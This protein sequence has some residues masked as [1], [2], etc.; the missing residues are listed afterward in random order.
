VPQTP[1]RLLATVA[2]LTFTTVSAAVLIPNAARAQERPPLPDLTG[3]VKDEGWAQ[4]LGK[5][6]F[7]DTVARAS[8]SDCA[9]CH[10]VTGANR[11]IPDQSAPPLQ[12]L[13]AA[14]D[15]PVAEWLGSVPPDDR[16][17]IIDV[18]SRRISAQPPEM[19]DFGPL[20][21]ASRVADEDPSCKEDQTLRL[22]QALLEQKPLEARSINPDDGTF[23]PS[24]PHGNLVSPTGRGLERTYQWMIEQAFEE[25]LWKAADAATS[26]TP[27]D[28]AYSKVEKNFPLFWGIAVGV[29]ESTLDPRWT[30]DHEVAR[31][32]AVPASS[33]GQAEWE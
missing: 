32:L 27:A 5:A 18:C 17:G 20:R 11:R 26:Q 30:R 14:T 10:F 9:S 2:A 24:G 28:P 21:A 15:G 6:L 7:W 1:A 4:I 3:I 13:R 31:S 25:P 29:Y 23:G 22:A 16:S 8:G 19:P 12:V 33:H